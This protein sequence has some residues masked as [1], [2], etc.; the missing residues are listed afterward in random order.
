[1]QSMGFVI[2]IFSLHKN[3]YFYL[4]FVSLLLVACSGNNIDDLKKQGELV[5]LTRNAPTTWYQGREG[6][7][8]FEYDLVQ[9]Y[10]KHNNLKVRFIINDN[11]DELLASIQKGEAHIAA[12]GITRTASRE[13]RGYIFGPAYQQVKQQVVCRRS[14]KALPKKIED[15]LSRKLTVIAGSSY[16]E[17]LQQLKLNYPELQWQEI[18]DIST[19]Q[20]LERTWKKEVDC[21]IADSNII[22]ITRRYYPELATALSVTENESL[23]WVVSPK[24]RSLVADIEQWLTKIKANGEYAAIEEKYYGHIQ[25]Y[26]Y[27]DN[28][29]FTRRIKS[30]LPKHRKHFEKYAKK[31][32]LPWPLLAAQAYQESHWNPRARS[33]TGVRGMMM[34]TLNT[35]KSVGVKSRLDP[36]QSIRGGAK[37]LRQM[38]K[39]IPKEVVDEDRVWY[40]LAAYNVGMGHLRDAMKL[41]RQQNLNA[42]K[43]VDLK[44][45]FPLLSNKKYYRKL[46]YGYARGS[47][48]VRYVQRI[49]EYQQVLEQIILTSNTKP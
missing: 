20:L 45:V 13:E 49:R 16:A 11:F 40:A 14:A 42:S 32:N 39:R 8:G 48:P 22:K 3:N 31:Y 25:L 27:V 17:V 19:E 21:T 29:S 26:D 35:A 1:M 2:R 44:T 30:R 34:L 37:Y 12:A 4:L 10:A 15:L 18:A 36:V 28:R 43:W 6:D 33:P 47:E 5:V 23:A 9:S 41:A 46:K 24:W 38:I 7:T